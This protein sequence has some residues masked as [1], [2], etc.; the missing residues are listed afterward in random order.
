MPR[1][2][3]AKNTSVKET[4]EKETKVKKTKSI[5]VDKKST[6]VEKPKVKKTKKIVKSFSDEGICWETSKIILRLIDEDKFTDYTRTFMSGSSIYV[7]KD[8][9]GKKTKYAE[10]KWGKIIDIKEDEKDLIFIL[11]PILD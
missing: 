5:K 10:N 6:K 11:E 1:V 3:S 8:K 4:K 7:N 9:I 2:K